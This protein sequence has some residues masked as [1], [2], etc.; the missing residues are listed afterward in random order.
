MDYYFR[1]FSFK[2]I[3]KRKEFEKNYNITFIKEL[4]GWGK[5]KKI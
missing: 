3:N 5:N 4:K 2:Q 1:R